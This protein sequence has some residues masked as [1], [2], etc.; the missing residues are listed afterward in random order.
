MKA[1]AR[2]IIW[3]PGLDKDIEGVTTNCQACQEMAKAASSSPLQHWASPDRPWS[4]IHIDLAGPIDGSWLLVIVDAYSK[5][6]EVHIM[7]KTTSAAII[8]KLR[9]TF[10]IHGLPDLVVTDNG[11]NFVSHEMETFLRQNCIRH[12]RSATLSPGIQRTGRTHGADVETLPCEA[13][14]WATRRSCFSISSLLSSDT[15]YCNRRGSVRTL[16]GPQTTN[17]AGQSQTRCVRQ[18]EEEEGQSR[19]AE[20][21]AQA[22]SEDRNIEVGSSVRIK[23]YANGGL[24]K[25]ALVTGRIGTNMLTCRLNDGREVTRHFDQV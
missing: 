19:A 7:S 9:Q 1:L 23:D 20:T 4:R 25:P 21:E 17:P 6:T 22:K 12:V 13:G 5:W 2:S 14:Q 3:W 11:S 15:A 10:T 8:K 24:W 16:Y 18:S